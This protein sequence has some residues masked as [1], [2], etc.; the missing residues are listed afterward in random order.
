VQAC[1][2]LRGAVGCVVF[3]RTS[4]HIVA[5]SSNGVDPTGWIP[6]VAV[7]L[8]AANALND[9][10]GGSDAAVES[11]A[12][13]DRHVI[14]SRTLAHHPNLGIAIGFDKAQANLVLQR[15]QLQRLDPMLDQ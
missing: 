10:L 15:A 1:A 9:A 7:S 12:T 11:V 14:L 2:S 13:L 4:R 6:G 8:K 5:L 3:D